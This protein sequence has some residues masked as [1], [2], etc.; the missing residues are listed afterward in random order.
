MWSR[1]RAFGLL[2]LVLLASCGQHHDEADTLAIKELLAR[3]VRAMD[4]KNLTLYKSLI[5]ADYQVGD[6]TRDVLVARMNG[7]FARFDRIRLTYSDTRIEHDRG[8]AR[9]TQRVSLRVSGLDDPLSDTET[10]V[11]KKRQGRWWIVGGL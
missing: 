9:V 1:N 11:L 2:L 10:L 4:S 8:R 6:V 7:Y 3:R 5:A